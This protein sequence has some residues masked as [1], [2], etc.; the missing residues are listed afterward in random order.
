M[1]A[2]V[3]SLKRIKNKLLREVFGYIQIFYTVDGAA[4][5][6]PT[7]AAA[8]AQTDSIAAFVANLAYNFKDESSIATYVHECVRINTS[9][10]NKI[11][12]IN[13]HKLLH[14]SRTIFFT[15]Y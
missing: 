9:L 1:C 14:K 13:S 6:D 15:S 10:M 12:N 8:T 7:A 2:C 4:A 5:T 11:K 3:G